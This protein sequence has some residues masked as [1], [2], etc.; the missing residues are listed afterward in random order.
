MTGDFVFGVVVGA[1]SSIAAYA[2]VLIY[3]AHYGDY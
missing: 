1:I 3:E 2:V